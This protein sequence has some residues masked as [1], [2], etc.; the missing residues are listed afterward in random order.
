MSNG[1]V[2]PAV[3]VDMEGT[4]IDVFLYTGMYIFENFENTNRSFI[5]SQPSVYTPRFFYLRF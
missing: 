1:D 2:A 4:N 3:M 5:Y